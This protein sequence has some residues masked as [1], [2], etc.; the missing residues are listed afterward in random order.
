MLIYSFG[1][2]YGNPQWHTSGNF[3]KEVSFANIGACMV[4]NLHVQ[5]IVIDHGSVDESTAR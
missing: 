3:E 1:D 2:C 4:D 5:I